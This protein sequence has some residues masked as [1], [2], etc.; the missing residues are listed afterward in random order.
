MAPDWHPGKN[1]ELFTEWAKS[2]GITINGVFPARFPGRGLGMM[3]TKNIK[4][5]L[6]LRS[7]SRHIDSLA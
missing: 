6:I 2:Q 7:L 5:H 3:A 1:H 4:V